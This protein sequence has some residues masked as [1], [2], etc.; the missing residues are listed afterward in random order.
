MAL[1]TAL[2]SQHRAHCTADHTGQ[3]KC[4]LFSLAVLEAAA[5][6][7]TPMNGIRAA[8]AAPTHISMMSTYG[9][10]FPSRPFQLY[11]A[12]HLCKLTLRHSVSSPCACC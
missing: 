8:A 11:H 10:P 6:V 2:I 9:D 4:L 7:V 3:M 1:L 12:L 5:L